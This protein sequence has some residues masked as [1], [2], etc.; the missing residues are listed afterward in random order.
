MPHEDGQSLT[1]LVNLSQAAAFEGGGTAF[2]SEPTEP[3]SQGVLAGDAQPA[4]TLHPNAGVGVV[5]N[6]T[7]RH[8]G[9]PVTGAG[10]R[11]VLVS[12]FSITNPEYVSNSTKKAK[13]IW[14]SNGAC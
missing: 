10:V 9:Q 8:A 1:V 6:G 5:F 11:Y 7:V 3:I 14:I 12:S 2:W 13:R 4:F